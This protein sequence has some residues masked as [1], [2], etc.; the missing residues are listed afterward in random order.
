MLYRRRTFMREILDASHLYH[1]SLCVNAKH[2]SLEPHS[3][4]NQRISGKKTG[5]CSGHGMY[6]HYP[7]WLLHLQLQQKRGKNLLYWGVDVQRHYVCGCSLPRCLTESA[8]CLA[9]LLV[10]RP[11]CS[12]F[13]VSINMS[14]KFVYLLLTVVSNF[15]E[16]QSDLLTTVAE[17]FAI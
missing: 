3:V 5:N 11:C 4:N 14:N 16:F 7:A 15:M 13:S 10:R 8:G 12:L 17:G 6:L 1:N 9:S 2:I